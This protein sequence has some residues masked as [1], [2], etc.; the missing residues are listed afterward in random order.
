[1]ES[2]RVQGGGGDKPE[3]RVESTTNNKQEQKKQIQKQQQE[4]SKNNSNNRSSRNSTPHCTRWSEMRLHHG[5]RRPRTLL[6]QLLLQ[7]AARSANIEDTKD[8]VQKWRRNVGGQSR[9]WSE[10]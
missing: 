2:N 5:I 6:H 8:G 9:G 7:G 10:Q 4:N 3:G 1:V